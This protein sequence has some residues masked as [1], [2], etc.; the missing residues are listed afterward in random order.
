MF[1]KFLSAIILVFAFLFLN[2]SE[3]QIALSSVVASAV[4]LFIAPIVWAVLNDR[5]ALEK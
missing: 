2:M 4:A 1:K 5:K 3:V